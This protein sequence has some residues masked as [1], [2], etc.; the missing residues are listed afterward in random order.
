MIDARTRELLAVIGS[1]EPIY[2]FNR[3]T[4]A[5]RQPGSTWKPIEFAL[6]LD[7]RKFTPA[8]V[9]LDAP[10]VYDQWKPN[11]Y[12][13]WHYTGEVRLREALAQS[14][15]L[16]AIR[17]VAELG[18]Q[19]VIDFAKR[20]GIRSEL[21]PTLALALGA[22]AVKPIELVNAYT[23]FAAGGQ[24]APLRTVRHIRGPDGKEI[25]LQP[26]AAP[27][28]V[29]SPAGAYLITSMMTSVVQ[30]GTGKAARVLNRPI[31]GKTGT[32]N[33]ARDAWFVGFTPEL[34]AGV[35]V[36]YD[37]L[38]PLGP[39][40]SGANSALPIWIDLMKVILKNRPAVD[41]PMPDG[42]TLTKIDPKSGKLAYENQPDAIDEVFMDGTLP[43]EVATPPDVVDTGTFMMEQLGDGRADA[44][45]H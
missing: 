44:Q 25:K 6:A 18:P 21:E 23:T 37:D 16:V 28:Q 33:K 24:F 45:N 5:V 43:T 9:L 3:A 7:Q 17:V 1:D 42:L 15:N 11:N 36:G 30:T 40:E 35:W 8:S 26:L 34:V 10:E 12:E 32:S 4:Q 13:T 2:G 27:E 22:S 39:H 14:I 38:R 20:L 19:S 29:M 31:A 41:F